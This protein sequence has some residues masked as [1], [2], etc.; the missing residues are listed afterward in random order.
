MEI[1]KVQ[2]VVK[3]IVESQI[4]IIG[5]LAIEQARKVSGLKISDG[6]NLLIEVT[7]NDTGKIIT[8]LVDK[9]QELFGKTSLE[10]CRDAMKEISD[11]VPHGELPPIL[12]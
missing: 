8:Q 4:S 9:Y 1:D 7:G 11:V 10:V 2:I 5:P 3:K 6:G 12:Q